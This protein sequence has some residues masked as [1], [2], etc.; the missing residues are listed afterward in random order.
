MAAL[1]TPHGAESLNPLFVEDADARAQLAKDAE[2]MPSITISSS[3][4]GNAVMLGGGYFTPLNGF[5]NKTN[6]L[7]I[8]KSMKTTDGLFWPN[9]R[10]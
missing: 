2:S 9:R 4:A 3:A 8:G 10:L 7:S 5:M 6:A 1:I